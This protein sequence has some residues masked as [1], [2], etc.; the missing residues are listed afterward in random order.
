MLNWNLAPIGYYRD[1]FLLWSVL[2]FSVLAIIN[3]LAAQSRVDLAYGY[4]LAACA[5]VAIVLAKERLVVIGGTAFVALGLAIAIAITWNWKAYGVGLFISVGVI[6]VLCPRFAV[7]SR[8]MKI[9]LKPTF[10]GSCS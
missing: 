5:I 8:A 6:L 1:R 2:L 3:T 10:P 4:K 9:P 7:G